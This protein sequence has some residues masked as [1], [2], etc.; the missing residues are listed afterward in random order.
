MKKTILTMI[1]AAAAIPANAQTQ[2]AYPSEQSRA[3]GEC[4]AL[5]STG[6]DRIVAMRWM[7]ANIG[8]SSV[9][10]DIVTVDAEGKVEADRAMAALFTRLF[11]Q[12]CGE[13]AAVLMKARDNAGIESAGARLGQI[14]MQELMG[15]PAVMQG[16]TA[17]V[18]YIDASAFEELLK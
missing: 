8:S 13:E 4:L 17:Y 2:I 3:L 12:D 18:Q 11:S 1:V 15:D 9:M 14:A 6:R 16:M 7:A 10:Q 5:S